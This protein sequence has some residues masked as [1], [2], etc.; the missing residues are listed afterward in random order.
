MICLRL[1]SYSETEKEPESRCPLHQP[2]ALSN[3]L[4]RTPFVKTVRKL[5]ILE[6]T[7]DIY[8]RHPSMWRI[9]PPFSLSSNSAHMIWLRLIQ[10]LQPSKSQGGHIPQALPIRMLHLL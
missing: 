9:T 3:T 8:L 1:H 7:C 4:E 2:N 6:Q 10:T 5:E